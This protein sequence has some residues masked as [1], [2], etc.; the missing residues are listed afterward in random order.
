MA[1]EFQATSS[2]TAKTKAWSSGI[3]AW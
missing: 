3:S 1:E 2:A